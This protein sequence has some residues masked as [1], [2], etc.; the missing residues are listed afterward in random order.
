MKK[1]KKNLMNMASLVLGVI[2]LCQTW[3][4]PASAASYWNPI[5]GTTEWVTMEG[6]KDYGT[7]TEHAVKTSIS[8]NGLTV[9]YTG[10]EYTGG[11]PNAGV[12]Y[13][14]PVSLDGFS[15]EFTVTKRADYYNTMGT[16]VDSWISLCLLNKPDK[17]FNIYKAGE[18][19]GI[20]TLIRPTATKTL[21]EICQLTNSWSS[22]SR[23]AYEST[24]DMRS[25][26]KVEIK[27]GADG[28]YDYI[29][30][31]VTFDAESYGGTDFTPVFTKLMEQG[32]VLDEKIYA[33][34][35]SD[36]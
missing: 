11:G 1:M 4:L 9:T 15:V 28:R 31:R 8:N 7:D 23:A 13:A 19:Q 34:L 21:F 18:S 10:G 30:D 5:S 33:I 27:K 24:K 29:V 25:T 3:T 22:A 20:V 35:D 17:Y 36:D 16:G 2:M 26:F 32:K 6:N 14:I 12:M